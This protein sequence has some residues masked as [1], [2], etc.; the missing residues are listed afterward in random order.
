MDPIET[1]LNVGFYFGR[2]SGHS[3]TKQEQV[4]LEKKLKDLGIA[5]SNTI[6]ENSLFNKKYDELHEFGFKTFS[7]GKEVSKDSWLNIIEVDTKESQIIAKIYPNDFDIIEHST[8]D[9]YV[10]QVI[11]LMSGIS[12]DTLPSKKFIKP[13][14]PEQRAK[15]AERRAQIGLNGELYIL[16][17]E[18]SKLKS[19]N[20][21]TLGYP[22]HIAMESMSHGYDILSIDQDKNEI[23]IEVKTTTRL[24]KDQGSKSFF[25]SINE[26]N[27]YKQNQ[28]KYKLYRVYDVEG[29]PSFEEVDLTLIKK[30]PDGFICTY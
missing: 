24:K 6:K 23:Y 8:I 22:K 13:L 21:N 12:I 10:A 2:A 17:E 9:L 18:K 27:V 14:S 30:K 3:K 4:S 15:E 7:D 1:C 5:L 19:L 11:F 16:N 20:L 28:E 25:M 29:T 26:D